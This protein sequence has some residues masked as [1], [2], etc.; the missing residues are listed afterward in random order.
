[1]VIISVQNTEIQISPEIR[2]S[3]NDGKAEFY[4]NENNGKQLS[5]WYSNLNRRKN[6]FPIT[7]K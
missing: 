3:Y 7:K 5:K 4:N 6:E 1:M 2:G